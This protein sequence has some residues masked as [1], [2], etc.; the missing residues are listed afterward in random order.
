MLINAAMNAIDQCSQFTHD[1]T[2][3]HLHL[4]TWSNQIF[5]ALLQPK[6]TT[7]WAQNTATTNHRRLII[8]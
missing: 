8:V 4:Y 5:Q 1:N 2:V 3:G 6:I 7:A